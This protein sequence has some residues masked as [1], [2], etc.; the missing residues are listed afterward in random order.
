[1]PLSWLRWISIQRGEHATHFRILR[2]QRLS[3]GQVSLRLLRTLLLMTHQAEDLVR[4]KVIRLVVQDA[5][6]HP[7]TFLVTAMPTSETPAL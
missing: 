4:L 6:H 7:S 1:M 5:L 2:L 3:T